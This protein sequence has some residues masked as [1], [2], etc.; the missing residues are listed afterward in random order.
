M[1]FPEKGKLNLSGGIMLT[2]LSLTTFVLPANAI[3]PDEDDAKVTY[4]TKKVDWRDKGWE[5][6]WQDEFNGRKLDMTKWNYVVN[7]WGG[8]N[9]EQQCYVDKSDNFEFENGALHIV[10]RKENFTGSSEAV[11]SPHYN[12]NN[13]KTLPYTSGRI[14]SNNKGDWKYGRI[15]ARIK[16]PYGQGTWPAFWMLPTDE[17]YG[18]WAASGEIDI[19]EAVNLGAKTDQGGK[20]RD[21][22]EVRIHGTLHYGAGWPA[23][24]FSGAGFALPGNFNPA[25]N[26]HTYAVEWEEGEIR[27]YMDDI[28]FATQR[29]DDWYSAYKNDEGEYLRNPGHA[30]FDQ[31]FHLILNLAIGGA[32]VSKVN[33]KGI[34]PEIFPQRLSVDYIRV[35]QCSKDPETGKGCASISDEA[36]L[37]RR[38]EGH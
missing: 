16:L 19:M 33:E 1:K 18:G 17:V 35:Y 3:I 6:V 2:S 20:L 21:E 15:E 25:N 31:R 26:Y 38:G 11:G 4:P 32:W 23:N 29:S 8:G 28:H 13:T 22:P 30:P 12:P 34:N 5:L 14:R 10:A 37:V 9:E 27:W 7:C 24:V 36:K